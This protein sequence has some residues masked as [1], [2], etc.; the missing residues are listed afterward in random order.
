M[1]ITATQDSDAAMVQV[2]KRTEQTATVSCMLFA[3]VLVAGLPKRETSSFGVIIMRWSWLALHAQE[4]NAIEQPGE[5]PY[6]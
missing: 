6:A 2:A 3:F 1:P 4:E 5:G